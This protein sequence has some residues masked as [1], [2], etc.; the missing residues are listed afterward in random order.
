[1]SFKKGDKVRVKESG[2]ETKVDV[3]PIWCDD[4]HGYFAH[5]LEMIEASTTDE[6]DTCPSHESG[7]H[8]PDWSSLNVTHD[9]ETYID[10]S[11]VNCGRSGCVGSAK[12]LD[13]G[14]SW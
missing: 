13:E 9:S 3:P 11:C 10:V 5:E 14:I 1:M 6:D 8:V 12:T 7:E 2:K 4:G